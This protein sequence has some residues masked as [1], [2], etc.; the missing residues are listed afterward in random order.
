VIHR[1]IKPS[2]LIL[3]NSGRLMIT[4]FGI[5][6]VVDDNAMTLTGSFLGTPLYMSPE[7][8]SEAS[9]TDHRTDIY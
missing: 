4:D 2:N 7:Q 1:D 9:N 8:I 3:S 6:R 5:A